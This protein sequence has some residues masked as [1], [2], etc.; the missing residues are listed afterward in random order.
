MDGIMKAEAMYNLDSGSTCRI[1]RVVLYVFSTLFILSGALA[2]PAF[3]GNASADFTEPGAGCFDDLGGKDVGMPADFPKETTSGWDVKA[4]YFYYDRPAD[5]MYVGID[6]YGIAGD[7]DG[8]GDPGRTGAVLANIGGEDEPDLNGT[9]SIVLLLD[10]NLD[11]KYEL[12]VGVNGTA[13]ISSFGTYNFVGRKYAPA[14]GFG[15]RISPDPATL[16]AQPSPANPDVEFTIERFSKLPGFT[17]SPEESFSFR[18]EAFA[19]SLSDVGIGDDLVPGPDGMVVTFS[20]N[21][22]TDFN[23]SSAGDNGGIQ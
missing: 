17:F 3:T 22:K 5:T 1:W 4:L 20:S 11:S 23:V 16:H 9:E 13:G 7:A 8:D 6:F 21:G 12:A 19:G 15:K 2:N 10:T 18:F 14:F